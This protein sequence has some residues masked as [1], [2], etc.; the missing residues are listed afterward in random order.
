MSRNFDTLAAD[1]LTLPPD[2]RVRLA[3]AL[4]DS[5]DDFTE[6]AVAA[7]WDAEIESRVDEYE[8]GKVNGIPADDVMRE[9]RRRLDEARRVSSTSTP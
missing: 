9:A 2:E 6:A 4:F 5:V 3:E 7:D 8:S 1:V